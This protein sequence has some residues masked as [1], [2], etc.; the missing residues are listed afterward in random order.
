MQELLDRIRA[1]EQAHETATARFVIEHKMKIA[2]AP[3]KW[4]EL[5]QEWQ[6]KCAKINASGGS[7][8][9][10]RAVAGPSSYRK[11]E[12]GRR[13]ITRVVLTFYLDIPVIICDL[14]PDRQERIGFKP[15]ADDIPWTLNGSH[16]PYALI[17]EYPF[18][19]L[20]GLNF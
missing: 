18:G 16:Q 7:F 4:D 20:S 6:K 5:K 9:Y 17:V 3:R 2:L 13:A 12:L 15:V 11:G 14:S 19:V 8:R 1:E 10:G